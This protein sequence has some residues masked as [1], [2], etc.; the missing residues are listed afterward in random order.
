MVYTFE[1]VQAAY[2]P[3][4]RSL[5]ATGSCSSCS[6]VPGS[7]IAV[8]SSTSATAPVAPA[9]AGSA[10][11]NSNAAAGMPTPAPDVAAITSALTPGLHSQCDGPWTCLLS[12]GTAASPWAPVQASP[13]RVLRD[14]SSRLS[15]HQPDFFYLYRWCPDVDWL[16]GH[17]RHLSSGRTCVHVASSQVSARLMSV[18]Y[19]QVTLGKG[20]VC[21]RS[22]RTPLARAGST[23][24]RGLTATMLT[25]SA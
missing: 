12:A 4:A 14:C 5:P 10:S 22:I 6:D 7:G 24:L 2:I 9:T 21:R 3:R 15:R 18:R 25:P 11:D 1:R 23:R 20:R 16:G 17:S 13:S 8:G 19:M